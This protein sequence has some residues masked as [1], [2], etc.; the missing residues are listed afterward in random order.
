MGGTNGVLVGVMT[1]DQLLEEEEGPLVVDLLTDL[2]GRLPHVLG[3]KSSAVWALTVGDD[4]LD[5]EDLL[6]DG[7]GE[8][9]RQEEGAKRRDIQLRP[10]H[11][12]PERQKR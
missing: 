5:L 3:G 7:I 9:L 11:G 10:D 4:V 8:D 6:E 2:D 12:T 1:K